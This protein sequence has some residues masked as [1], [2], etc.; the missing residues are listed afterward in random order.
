MDRWTHAHSQLDTGTPSPELMWLKGQVQH[1]AVED[2]PRAAALA[3]VAKD[4]QASQ[5]EAYCSA[6]EN[7]GRLEW[8]CEP[9]GWNVSELALALRRPVSHL[10][11]LLIGG[12]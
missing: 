4:E 9:G 6:S 11:Y 5:A 10:A 1:G 2:R 8:D 12:A 3:P 7:V